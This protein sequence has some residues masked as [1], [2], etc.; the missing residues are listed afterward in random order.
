M[1]KFAWMIVL[2]VATAGVTQVAAVNNRAKSISDIMVE[3]HKGS[4]ALCA[5][6]SKGMASKDDI[7]VLVALYTDLGMNKPSK[8]DADS[9][10]QKCDALLAAAKGLEKDP[11]DKAAIKAY[12]AAVNCAGCH[13]AHK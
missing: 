2:A 13:K 10:K 5:K 4:P 11:T 9:W 7:K 8:G 6:A 1:R 3:G 12:A